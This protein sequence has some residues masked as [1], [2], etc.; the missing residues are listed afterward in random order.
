MDNQ[1]LLIASILGIVAFSLIARYF[2]RYADGKANVQGSDKKEK[3]LEWQETHGASLK[4]AIKVLSI[5]FGV[6]MLFQV[7]SLL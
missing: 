7:L 3:Y 2:Y 6:L 5:I 4:K 1:T